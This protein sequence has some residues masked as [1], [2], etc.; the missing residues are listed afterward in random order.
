MTYLGKL[1]LQC[2]SV[3]VVLFSLLGTFFIPV[4]PLIIVVTLLALF[5]WIIKIYCI[6]KK[7]GWDGIHS[8]RMQDTFSK[9]ILY[10]VFI[11]L[12]FI[13]DMFF[14]KPVLGDL[15]PLIFAETTAAIFAKTLVLTVF[16]TLMIFIREAKSI[17]EN[18]YEGF[19]FSPLK[20]FTE[21]LSFLFK[22]KK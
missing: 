3:F 5:D 15:I 18:L 9:I 8:N 21:N 6:L 2:K 17:D 19:G 7:D 13:I 1:L 20:I 16:G 4:K 11:S 10:A 22:W 14:V 12:M